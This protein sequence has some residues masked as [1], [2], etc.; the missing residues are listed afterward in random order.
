MYGLPIIRYHMVYHKAS[1]SLSSFVH[2]TAYKYITTK[3][4][5]LY[6]HLYMV[7]PTDTLPVSF[8]TSVLV[9]TSLVWHIS[10]CCTVSFLL[11]TWNSLPI[12]VTVSVLICR[13]RRSISGFTGHWFCEPE[14]FYRTRVF[15]TGPNQIKG[16]PTTFD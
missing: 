16:I 10:I 9:C 11:C 2:G 1:L 7:L 8:T 3:L 4:Q 6:P 13:H 14:I 15:F 5:C 12:R